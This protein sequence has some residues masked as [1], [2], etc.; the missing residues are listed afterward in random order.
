MGVLCAACRAV[1]ARYSRRDARQHATD[2]AR[3]VAS[4]NFPQPQ[5]NLAY[6]GRRAAISPRRAKLCIGT[7]TLSLARE[8][9]PSLLLEGAYALSIVLALIARGASGVRVRGRARVRYQS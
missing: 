4:D 1:G 2:R 5:K 8:H 9:R 3:A 7:H 6:L